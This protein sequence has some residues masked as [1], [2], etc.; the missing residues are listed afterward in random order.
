MRCLQPLEDLPHTFAATLPCNEHARVEDY[1]RVETS[2][3]LRLLMISFRSAANSASR[4][5]S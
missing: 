4:V 1:A 3:G 2:R 5:G